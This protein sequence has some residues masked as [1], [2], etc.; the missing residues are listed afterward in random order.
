MSLRL[1]TGFCH[2]LVLREPAAETRPTASRVRSAV[3][4]SLQDRVAGAHFLDLFAGSGAVGI[5]A[6]SRGARAATFV[7]HDRAALQAL[8]ANL[9]EVQKRASKQAIRCETKI[10]AQDA[11]HAIELC[12]PHAFEIIWLDPPYA[13]LPELLPALGPALKRL[14]A[15]EGV[16][17]VESDAKEQATVVESLARSGWELLK[18]KVYGRIAV[19]YLNFPSSEAET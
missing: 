7:E 11:R 19:T 18:Q 8:R 12:P 13:A 15:P 5:E 1:N 2:G 3:F 17:L 16:L 14:L 9:E 6:L 10:L 4:N